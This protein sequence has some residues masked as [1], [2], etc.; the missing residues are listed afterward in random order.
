MQIYMYMYIYIYLKYVISVCS[1]DFL[2]IF[3][4]IEK[5]CRIVWGPITGEEHMWQCGE[6]GNIC[7]PTHFNCNFIRDAEDAYM[8][9]SKYLS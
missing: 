5:L 1:F 8:L 2:K 9:S 6:K 3:H 7:L 4:Q